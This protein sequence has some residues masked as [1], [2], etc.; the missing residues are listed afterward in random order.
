[1]DRGQTTAR[2]GGLWFTT[3]T[4]HKP[5]SENSL[6]LDPRTDLRSVSQTPVHG[7]KLLYPD[8]DTNYGRPSQ[9]IV[10]YTVQVLSIQITLRSVFD[11]QFSRISG[12][13]SFFED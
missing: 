5:S 7:S 12:E 3:V 6:S 13:S 9:T 4:P 1:M 11:L 2:A 10:R 8:S